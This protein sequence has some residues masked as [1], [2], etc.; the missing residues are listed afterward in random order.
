MKTTNV[1]IVTAMSSCDSVF[2][3]MNTNCAVNEYN[4]EFYSMVGMIEDACI[5]G[6]HF[7]VH[8]RTV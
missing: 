8:A 6:D 4:F 2:Q 1:A 3:L 7:H 5:W